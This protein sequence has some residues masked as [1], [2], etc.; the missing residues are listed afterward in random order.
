MIFREHLIPH[1]RKSKKHYRLFY[2][3]T[4]M[5]ALPSLFYFHYSAPPC[6]QQRTRRQPL[7][8][9]SYLVRRKPVTAPGVWGCTRFQKLQRW[10]FRYKPK[11]TRLLG[12]GST[13]QALVSQRAIACEVASEIRPRHCDLSFCFCHPLDLSPKAI[14]IHRTRTEDW[15]LWND[16]RVP[17]AN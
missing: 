6:S 4:A 13:V 5:F 14:G 17:C 1:V 10:P 11:E 7:R 3:E 8:V 2:S 12:W 15:R 9:A 16:S